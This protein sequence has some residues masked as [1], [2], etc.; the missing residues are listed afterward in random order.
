MVTDYKSRVEVEKLNQL[1]AENPAEFVRISEEKYRDQIKTVADSFCER[2]SEN[3]IILLAGPSS[4]GKTTTSYNLQMELGRRGI[5]TVTVSLD[6]FF[7]NREQVPVLPDGSR[8]FETPDILDVKYLEECL[9]KLVSLG[10]WEFPVFSF[11]EGCRSEETRTLHFD[12]HTAIIV[13]GLHALNPKFAERDFFCKA[14]KLY[15]SIKTEYYLPDGNRVLNT[16]ETRLIRRVIRDYNFR[17]CLPERTIQMWDNVVDG[18]E[19]YIRPYRT[20]ADFWIDSLHFYEPLV[21]KPLFF[22]LMENFP[23]ES[24]YR[25]LVEKLKNGLDFFAELP[26]SLIP[27]DS[28]LR[29][30][31]IFP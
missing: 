1:A 18:E 25:D 14:L 10:E 4:S 6:D 23:S 24:V 7:I 16:R 5:K 2:L 30:F 19:K 22:S 13:E 29:E 26:V 21:Y 8:D 9:E 31:I 28:L 3:K 12:A 17:G 15:I 27:A 11:V 20:A